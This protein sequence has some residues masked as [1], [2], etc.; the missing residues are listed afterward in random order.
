MGKHKTTP[1]HIDNLAENEVFV[2]GSNLG[3]KHNGGAAC[4]ARLKFGGIQ[5]QGVGL[6]GQSY[7]IPIKRLKVEIIKQFVDDFIQF[8]KEHTEL[9][10]SCHTYWLWT[11]W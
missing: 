5:G 2:F 3:G 9:V 10:F 7:A 8:A 4:T 11:F 1:D 6:Q